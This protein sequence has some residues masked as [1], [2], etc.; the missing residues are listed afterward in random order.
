[1]PTVGWHIEVE[2]K[3]DERDV[4]TAAALLLRLPDGTELRARGQAK[5]NPADPAQPRIGEEIAAARALS[6]LVHQLLDKAAS[7]IEAVTHRPAHLRT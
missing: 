3:E 4:N 2:F 6:D 5:R 7:E 1:M